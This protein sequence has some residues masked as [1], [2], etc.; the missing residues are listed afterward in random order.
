MQTSTDVREQLSALIIGSC[1]ACTDPILSQAIAKGPFADN[2][3]RRPLREFISSEAG[4]NDG[5]GFPFLLLAVALLR[6]AEAPDNTTSLEDFDLARGIPDSLGTA[7][8]GRFGGGVTRALR[9]WAIEGVLYMMVLGSGYGALIGF[10]SRKLLNLASKRYVTDGVL[11]R[12]P[13][14]TEQEMD[15]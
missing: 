4:G 15:R 11:S 13:L 6:Y 2:Y 1:V 7:D 14:T 10:I 8:I 12:P 5:F 9:H 3:V